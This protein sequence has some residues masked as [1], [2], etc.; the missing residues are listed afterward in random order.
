MRCPVCVENGQT[1]LV[2]SERASGST[3]VAGMDYWDEND[4]LHVHDPSCTMCKHHCTN[5]H[6]MLMLQYDACPS[7]DY[8]KDR[9]QLL[10]ENTDRGTV[11]KY[12][13]THDTWKRVVTF[14]AQ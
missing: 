5:G 10:V 2:T 9:T 7:C 14:A 13:F 3:D 8:N 11:T 6:E 1:S 12:R 4:K